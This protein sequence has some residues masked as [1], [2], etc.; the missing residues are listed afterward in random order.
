MELTIIP[1]MSEKTVG[2]AANGMYTFEVP[3]TATKQQVAGAVA[4][5]YKV[6]VVSVNTVTAEGKTKR[7]YRKG[8]KTVV[9][10]RADVKKAY[11][12]LAEG[13]KISAF[14]PPAEAKETK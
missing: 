5:Q 8:G 12:R 1:R 6:K 11:V 14:D 4:K 2:Q 13:D 10:K 7:S 9:G 3:T